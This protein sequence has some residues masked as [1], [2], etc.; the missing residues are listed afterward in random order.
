MNLPRIAMRNL[1]RNKRRT[2]ITS[3][4]MSF[5]LAIMIVY[6]GLSEGF[7]RKFEENAIS[8]D[9]SNIQIH[10]MDYRSDPSIY[11]WIDD[12]EDI[13]T[14]LDKAGYHASPRWNG[15]ALAAGK[16]TSAG[17]RIRG[18]N[19]LRESD[20]TDLYRHIHKGSWLLKGKMKEVVIGRK[21]AKTLNVDI[22]DEIVLLGQASDG[23]MANDIY[24]VRGV[25]K[26]VS[27]GIDRAGFFMTEA[28]FRDLLAYTGGAH[29]IAVRIPATESLDEAA[30]IVT[31]LAP[32]DE[33][34]TWRQLAPALS[35]LLE[36]S[37]VSLYFMYIIAYAAIG[38]VTLNAMLMA[39]FER[40]R[41]FGIMKAVGVS[42][43]QITGMIFLESLF[44]TA[45][46]SFIG[47]AVGLPAS[48]YL[49]DHGIDLTQ[50][51]EGIAI[52]GVAMDPIW[53]TIVTAN[54]VIMPIVFMAAI[55]A[56][57][58]IYPG[59]KAAMVRP[60]KAIYHR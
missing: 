45:L 37:D 46:A 47:I 53:S 44:Q 43:F 23:S 14:R 20:V 31:S 22:G 48:L 50:F 6:S 34:M 55:V 51:G 15:F 39:V 56:L 42:P 1:A 8:L 26:T 32:D 36:S 4:A 54:T 3:S 59:F 21:L 17:V 16:L 11:C 30:S 12:T 60:V 28:A 18:V 19:T 52:S 35:Q 27:A 24:F 7:V 41:E 40:I 2:I 13:L 29:E 49:R 25:L 58:V 38:M 9:M 33:T 10:A 5:A 57:A